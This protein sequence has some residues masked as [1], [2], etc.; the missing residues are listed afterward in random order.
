MRW[1]RSESSV[2]EEGHSDEGSTGMC[3]RTSTTRRTSGVAGPSRM[4]VL[5][6]PPELV[7]RLVPRAPV[8]QR[9]YGCTS[10]V[11]TCNIVCGKGMDQ[12]GTI[13]QVRGA[14]CVF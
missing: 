9:E 12:D 10:V 7:A 6:T 2:M 4:L 11:G 8:V 14:E 3:S 13:I 5:H 1:S